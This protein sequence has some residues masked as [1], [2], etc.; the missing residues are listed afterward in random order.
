VTNSNHQTSS[1]PLLAPARMG[2]K[3]KGWRTS[4][5]FLGLLL[6]I[7]TFI[8]YKPAWN[9]Q[10]VFDDD[11]HLTPTQLSSTKGLV[12]IWTELGAVSQY[13]PV[14]HSVF[15]LQSKAWGNGMLGYHL[16]NISLHIA[17]ALL[18]VAILR[19]LQVP[20]AWLAGAIFALHPVH[21]ESVAWISELKN[22]LSGV[23]YLGAALAYLRFAWTKTETRG[24]MLRAPDLR[25][26]GSPKKLFYILALIFFGLGLLSKSVIAS[27]PAAL[28]IVFWWK[29]GRISWKQDVIPLL[30]FFVLGISAGLF[31]AWVEK[32]F[33]GAEGEAFA[34]TFVERC[35]IAGR[36]TW[37]YL[38]K[39]LWPAN[40]I[41][42]YPRWEV[43][44]GV[45][46]QHIFP[47]AA[48]AMAIGL[49][50]LRKQ[51][52]GPLAALLFFVGTLFPALGFINVYPFR[53]SFVADHYQYLASIGVIVATAAGATMLL[54]RWHAL[55]QPVAIIASVACLLGLS[56]LSWKQSRIY[57]DVETLW[58]TTIARNPDCFVAHSNLGNHFLEAGR[59]DDAIYHCQLAI[60]LQPEYAEIHNNLA[61]AL[62]QKER[63]NE[64]MHHYQRA[65]ELRPEFGVAHYN[66]GTIHMKRGQVDEA[67]SRFQKAVECEP[68]FVKARKNLGSMLL[69][70]GRV[71]EAMVQFE[72]ALE[73]W[74]EDEDTLNNLG[75]ALLQK[76]ELEK[77]IG[78]YERTLRS[79]PGHALA[80][81]NLGYAQ[82]LKGNPKAATEYLQ[83]AVAIQPDF[84]QAHYH[85][86]TAL[87][88]IGRP[89]DAVI[90]Y[91]ETL[92]LQPDNV[93]I[94]ATMA[95]LLATC[96][97]DSVRNGDQAM[98]F[99]R[100]AAQL[101]GGQDVMVLRALSAAYAEAGRFADAKSAA[102]QA[103][104]LV[105]NHNDGNLTEI[106]RLE[107]A[108]Y[109]AGSPVRD[110][111]P[112]VD[113]K[114]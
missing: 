3:T 38:G 108:L 17:C 34:L 47:V 19:R 57:T 106:L 37:F 48:V 110:K 35:L 14:T 52:R 1:N 65:L 105:M 104:E 11:D 67:I 91:R 85:L 97:E 42:I 36:A 59:P 90:H 32:R 56:T 80:L 111:L 83:K 89:T 68:D 30:P 15:W 82:L 45:L 70:L 22:T 69:D 86:A 71:D 55:Q 107:M 39:L 63:L 33:I 77:A 20:G 96:P 27:L 74:P 53:Y 60:E 40:L 2:T 43:S 10:P 44:Q 79:Q 41:F 62:L 66:L 13:Y 8:A 73:V 29:R 5:W 64:A 58:R 9:G 99:G 6:A 103:L 16:L 95:W 50:A 84:P 94:L 26:N 109:Q 88:Q 75:N 114:D 76:G 93:E 87:M 23:F 102:Q 28:L 7:V 54:R 18:L 4:S 61:N 92:R 49:W 101:T 72:K 98:K 78:H 100:Q 51:W 81:C 25:E 31:T 21:V 24:A 113:R 12:R 46:W 112:A